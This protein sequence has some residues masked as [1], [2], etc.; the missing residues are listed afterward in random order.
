MNLNLLIDC[1]AQQFQKSCF[2]DLVHSAKGF[3]L[4]SD[5]RLDFLM[6]KHPKSG[7]QHSAMP[8]LD[9][10]V[11]DR[12]LIILSLNGKRKETLAGRFL[13]H[14]DS[15]WILDRKQEMG[16]ATKVPLAEI[17]KMKIEIPRKEALRKGQ[18]SDFLD[19]I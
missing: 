5:P 17:G 8:L 19:K 2:L 12:I 16:E 14:Q 4:D 15:L 18:V 11:N 10:T 9:V 1:I 13:L 6:D 3:L 7:Y